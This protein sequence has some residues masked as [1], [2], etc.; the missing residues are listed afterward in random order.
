[1]HIHVGKYTEAIADYGKALEI[2]PKSA[3]AYYNRGISFDRQGHYEMA[4]EDFVM[5][6]HLNK[7]NADFY[8][9]KAFCLRKMGRYA[10]S[11]ICYACASMWKY[12]D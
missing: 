2:D 9:N 7:N 6:I 3:F 5:A 8:H 11:M 12:R 1:M 4:Y 10:N